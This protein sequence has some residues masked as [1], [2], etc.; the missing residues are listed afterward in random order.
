MIRIG[1]WP[2]VIWQRCWRNH[3]VLL[4]SLLASLVLLWWLLWLCCRFCI[5]KAACLVV[6]NRD[7]LHLCCPVRAHYLVAH[8]PE[9][10]V[11]EDNTHHGVR[12][13]CLRLYLALVGV[14]EAC[15]RLSRHYLDTQ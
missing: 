2:L 14:I 1:S 4:L 5:H 12:D 8:E 3:R 13:D 6:A 15:A 7:E 9:A 10:V 11:L